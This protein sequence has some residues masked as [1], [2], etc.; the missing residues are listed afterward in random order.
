[1]AAADLATAGGDLFRFIAG[2]IS[3]NTCEAT[4]E[5]TEEE[6]E[7]AYALFWLVIFGTIEKKMIKRIHLILSVLLL[8]CLIEH[9]LFAQSKESPKITLSGPL[10]KAFFLYL[11]GKYQEALP[12]AKDGLKEVEKKRGPNHVDVAGG[13]YI[14]ANIYHSMKAYAEAEPLYKRMLAIYENVL[15]PV[16]PTVADGLHSLACRGPRP[17]PT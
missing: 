7:L 8:P 4:K 6:A 9:T 1:L 10:L 5:K 3:S 16:D 11:D 15:G 12:L 14:L 13:L 2:G 17:F